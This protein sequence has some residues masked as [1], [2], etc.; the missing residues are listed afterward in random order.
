MIQ[1][2]NSISIPE[3]E[4]Q[5]MAIRASGPGGQHVNKSSTAIQLKFKIS[6][7]SLPQDI[8]P[9]LRRI[10][11]SHLSNDDTIVIKAQNHRSQKMNKAE[12]LN[13]LIAMIIES[14]KKPKARKQTSIPRKEK[15]KRLKDKKHQSLKKEYRKPPKA[16][17]D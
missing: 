9:R 11:G 1:V 12:A 4:I 14:T 13:R 6:I 10:A 8:I 3:K 5:Y 7:S 16:E 17:N 2:T 15:V